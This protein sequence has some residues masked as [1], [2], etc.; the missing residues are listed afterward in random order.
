MWVI[1]VGAVIV[2]AVAAFLVGRRPGSTAAPA[3]P[4]RPRPA[5]AEFHVRGTRALVSF[6]VPLPPGEDA[7]LTDLLVHEAIEVV[8]EKRHTLPIDDVHEVAALARRDGAFVEVGAHTLETPGVLPEPRVPDLLP[9]MRAVGFDP[10]AA[11]DATGLDHAPGLRDRR[12]ESEIGNAGAELRLSSRLETAL[13][14][15][16]IDPGAATA[17]EVVLAVLRVTGSTISQQADDTYVASGVGGRVYIEVVDHQPGS[18]PELAESDID[19]FLIAFGSSG[20]SQGLC[21]SDKYCPFVVYEK[22][23]RQPRVRFITRERLQD[24]VDALSVA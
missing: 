24:F 8:R 6:D 4:S 23:R 15:Q 5:V 19:G 21:V 14:A 22:E 13:R 12:R 16:G 20:A 10:V 17:G 9:H 3:A 7:V 18:Y 2:V 1:V 11:V